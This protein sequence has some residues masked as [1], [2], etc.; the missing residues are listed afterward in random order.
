VQLI[1][2]LPGD[3]ANIGAG[4]AKIG[5][6]AIGAKAQFVQVLPV[7]TVLLNTVAKAHGSYPFMFFCPP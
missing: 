3:P 2:G 6:I 5:E 4:N 7:L 1:A